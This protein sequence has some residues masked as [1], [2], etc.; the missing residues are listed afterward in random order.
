M[1]ALAPILTPSEPGERRSLVVAYPIVPESKADRHSSNA[2]WAADMSEGMNER[3]GR[4]TRARQRDDTDKARG[5]DAKLA[6][7][8]ALLRAYAVCTVTV[9][10]T[11]RVSEFGRRLDASIRRA[12][13]APLRLDL[14]QDVGFTSSTVPLGTSLTRTGDS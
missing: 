3:L 13:F 9:P 8:N 1:G 12:G 5:L 6:R 14:A 10:K 7:G 11:A 2:Q 4:R